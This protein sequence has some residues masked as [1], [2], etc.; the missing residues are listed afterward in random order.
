MRRYSLLLWALFILAGVGIFQPHFNTNPVLHFFAQYEAV[1]IVAHTIL[2]GTL[3]FLARKRGLAAPLALALTVFVGA[4]QEGVQ[5]LYAHRGPGL[6][7]LFD[8][9]VDATAAMLAMLALHVA[10]RRVGGGL[11]GLSSPRALEIVL[12][13]R[14]RRRRRQGSRS[15]GR[16]PRTR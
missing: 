12:R 6:P 2:Y 14:C 5:L 9:G 8:I 4:L 16:S 10:S 3:A 1:H 13:A 7:E 15:L 11:A